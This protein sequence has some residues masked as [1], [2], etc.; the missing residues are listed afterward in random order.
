MTSDTACIVASSLTIAFYSA[1]QPADLMGRQNITYG[2]S[3]NDVMETY[4]HFLE[5]LAPVIEPRRD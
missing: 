4:G 2:P 3:E 5:Q 1:I